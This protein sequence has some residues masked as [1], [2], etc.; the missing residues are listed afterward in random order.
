MLCS[1]GVHDVLN[2]DTIRRV[3]VHSD[4]EVAAA[5]LVQQA[6]LAGSRDNLSA[7]V[8]KWAEGEGADPEEMLKTPTEGM[9]R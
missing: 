6:M 9:E 3:V 1:D 5:Q 7:V 8:L 2:A 4:A